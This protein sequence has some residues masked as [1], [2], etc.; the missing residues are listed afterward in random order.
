MVVNSNCGLTMH[1][2]FGFVG[3]EP[4]DQVARWLKIMAEYRVLTWKCRRIDELSRHGCE[5]C[6]QCVRIENRDGG[7]SKRKTLTE[8]EQGAPSTKEEVEMPFISPGKGFCVTGTRT[9]TH[10]HT[11]SLSD[12]WIFSEG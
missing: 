11:C 5:D 6:K 9:G 2:L 4:S 8:I 12:T 1:L 10:R 3:E 7:P